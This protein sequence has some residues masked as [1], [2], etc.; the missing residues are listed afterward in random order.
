M[1]MGHRG[2]KLRGVGEKVRATERNVLCW[3][4]SGLST[5]REKP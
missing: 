2:A 5:G 3:S 4:H 1:V